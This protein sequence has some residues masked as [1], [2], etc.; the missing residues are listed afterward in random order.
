M[1]DIEEKVEAE[2]NRFWKKF[3][4]AWATFPL[5]MI[6]MFFVGRCSHLVY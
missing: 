6:V 3:T 2:G 1:S 5:M 4:K